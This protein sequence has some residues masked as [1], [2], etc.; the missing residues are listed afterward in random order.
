VGPIRDLGVRHLITPGNTRIKQKQLNVFSPV[1]DVIVKNNKE[2]VEAMDR[3]NQTKL[4]IEN[5]HTN[6]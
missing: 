2:L 3:I 1:I 6:V 5:H 4:E